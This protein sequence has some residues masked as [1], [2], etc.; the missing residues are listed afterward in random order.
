MSVRRIVIVGMLLLAA[1]A[2]LSAQ[3]ESQLKRLEQGKPMPTADETV[4]FR[5]DIPYIDAVKSLSELSKRLSGKI[6][7]DSSPMRESEKLIGINIESMYWKDA[8][9]YILRNNQLWYTEYP[10]YY[11]VMTVEDIARKKS[12]DAARQQVV[13]QPQQQPGRQEDAKQTMQQFPVQSQLAQVPVKVD[14]GEIFIKTAEVTI[15]SIFIELN[16]TKIRENGISLSLFR[17]KDLNLGVSIDGASRVGTPLFTASIQPT[18]KRLVVDVNSA[19]KMIESENLGEVVSRPQVTVRSGT[20]GR[21]QIGQKFSVRTKDFSQNIVEQFFDV[22]TIL[23]VRPTLYTVGDL[24]FCDLSVSVEKST[25]T[26]AAQ[27]TLINTTNA[28]T[29]LSL[30]NGEESYVGGLYSNEE[31]TIRE[32]IPFLKDL[33]WWVLGLRY[34]FGYDKVEVTKKELLVILKAEFS[35]V[36]E[37]RLKLRTVNRNVQQQKLEEIGRDIEKRTKKN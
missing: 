34:L 17:G 6:I 2:M 22:G 36:I 24:T 25:V 1:A 16:Q 37:E 4:S 14:S 8:L 35:P 15:S 20:I 11:E 12:E 26:P 30:L 5:A 7:V 3:T 32:G 10:E 13:A 23:S 29:R 21:M 31:N 19:I 33:P 27:T 9:E 28:S 18:D